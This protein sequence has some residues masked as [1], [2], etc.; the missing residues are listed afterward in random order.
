MNRSHF[1]TTNNRP[2]KVFINTMLVML[3][4][5]FATNTTLAQRKA[6]KQYELKAFNLAISS[7]LKYINQNPSSGEAM[8]NLADCYRHINQMR[9]GIGPGGW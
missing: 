9:R 1:T 8:A 5:V 2:M 7:N 3:L 6:N 4:F